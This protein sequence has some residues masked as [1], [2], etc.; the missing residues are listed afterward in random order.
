MP[1]HTCPICGREFRYESIAASKNYPFCSRR[2]RL[3]DLGKWLEGE[4]VVP[5]GEEEDGAKEDEEN[6]E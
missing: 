2:C 6:D 3:I 5:G 1:T 4:Y